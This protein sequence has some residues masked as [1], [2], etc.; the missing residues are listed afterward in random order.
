M[1]IA[2]AARS[3]DTSRC[4]NMRRSRVFSGTAGLLLG[5]VLALSANGVPAS[6]LA[7]QPTQMATLNAPNIGVRSGLAAPRSPALS[8]ADI[9]RYRAI[10][11][12]QDAAQWAAA[13][14]EIAR[15][16]DRRLMGHVLSQR[17]L[18]PTGWTAS[19][20]DLRD[21]MVAY[22]D[23]PMAPRI[24]ALAVQRRPG[25]AARPP[26]PRV[27]ATDR[28]WRPVLRFGVPLCEAAR[29]NAT[30]LSAQRRVR[31]ALGADQ[32]QRAMAHVHAAGVSPTVQ[33]RLLG[34]I[35]AYHYFEGQHRRALDTAQSAID[36]SGGQSERALWIAGLAHWQHGDFD[37]AGA[38]FGQL[39]GAVCASA[40]ERSAG[41]YWAARAALRSRDFQAVSGWLEQA[42]AHPF[43]F[44]G[45]MAGRALGQ[46]SRLRVEAPRLGN[47]HLA[48]L[49]Q[50]PAGRR[51][52]A[53]AQIGQVHASETE[54][55]AVHA[56]PGNRLLVEAKLA[57]A[58]HYGMPRLA[59]D[60]AT[61]HQPAPNA[62][63]AS[64]LFPLTAWAPATGWR[65]DQAL[66]FAIM[67]TESAFNPRAVSR[68]GAAGLM[69]LMPGTARAMARE[70]GR[71]LSRNSVFDPELNMA[72]GQA[73]VEEM[74]AFEPVDRDVI[75]ML[76]SYNAGP[77]NLVSWLNSVDYDGDPLL[78]VESLPSGQARA[79]VEHVMASLWIYRQRL[80]QAAPS[81]DALVAGDW[82]TYRAQDGLPPIEVAE[83]AGF[84]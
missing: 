79:Y 74:F 7:D 52:L 45:I 2:A 27:A 23:H 42:A 5:L 15:L 61:A 37:Q 56:G 84:Q 67:R 14:R 57:I 80:G 43:T 40:W 10:F 36:R 75:R 29:L 78:F 66:V 17:Y 35:A 25:G 13:D 65:V 4:R 6:A 68:S 18:H 28:P 47:G 44:Y 58:D 73:Y 46:D 34:D 22:A 69:Q 26:A 50:S 31:R 77:G 30:E 39:A 8:A 19:Y 64:G 59:N 60:V 1:L 9:A 3:G 81:L 76:V 21:W 16:V 48:Q 62:Y 72:L 33:D 41:A 54:L 12:R 71:P 24:H 38:A 83:H 51:G 20:A 55:M 70:I 49:G 32:P 11:E 63:Y 82:P 53:L